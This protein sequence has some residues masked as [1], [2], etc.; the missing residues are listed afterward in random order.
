VPPLLKY[1]LIFE[2]GDWEL[3][4]NNKK[5]TEGMNTKIEESQSAKVDILMEHA[6]K[7][8]Q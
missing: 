3:N 4:H 7:L 6:M 8:A 1:G 5:I 2:E